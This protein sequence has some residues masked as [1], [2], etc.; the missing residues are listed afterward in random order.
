[1]KVMVIGAKP[2]SLT[3]FRGQMLAAMV[4]AGHEVCAVAGGE[5]AAVEAQLRA[6]GV[7]YFPLP[8]ARTGL[9]PFRD[10]KFLW[11]LR[12]FMKAR[13]PDVVLTYT[14][15]PVLY[16]SLAAWLTR[17][18]KPAAMITGIGSAFE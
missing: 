12:R 11:M 3:N 16:G 8:L 6:L 10:L 9:N 2:R 18:P 14:V 13:R 4:K 1:M 5:D 17:V 7:A 15:K